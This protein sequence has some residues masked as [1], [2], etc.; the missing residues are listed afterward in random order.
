[1][2]NNIHLSSNESLTF[3]GMIH[4]TGSHPFCRSWTL[5][6]YASVHSH[7]DTPCR[8]YITVLCALSQ[9]VKLNAC[10]TV[11]PF[12]F[13][14]RMSIR[15]PS[16]CFGIYYINNRCHCMPCH[17]WTWFDWFDFHYHTNGIFDFMI[18]GNV[19]A[20]PFEAPMNEFIDWVVIMT[21]SSHLQNY[22]FHSCICGWANWAI[23]W[24]Y[25]ETGAE[26]PTNIRSNVHSVYSV[27]NAIS[28][29]ASHCWWQ[30]IMPR[31]EGIFPVINLV[32]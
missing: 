11:M 25:R 24:I 26:G 14:D 20:E 5:Q 19:C 29:I 28:A 3:Q 6:L 16:N 32:K 7:F 1:M 8:Q 23:K 15:I 12:P 10:R 4:I 27:Y 31:P 13:S 30:I 18:T 21:R 2:C 9:P 22:S 17:L